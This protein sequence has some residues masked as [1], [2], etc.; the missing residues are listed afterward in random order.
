MIFVLIAFVGYAQN[1]SVEFRIGVS[2]PTGDFGDTDPKNL[3]AGLAKTGIFYSL[4]Y[5]YWFNEVAGLSVLGFQSTNA[6]DEDAFENNLKSNGTGGSN[7]NIESESWKLRLIGIGPS[8]ET[9][10]ADK[11]NLKTNL[12]IGLAMGSSA[13]LSYDEIMAGLTV[14]SQET[15]SADGNGLAFKVGVALEYELNDQWNINL[16]ADYLGTTIEYTTTTTSNSITPSTS[17]IERTYDQAMSAYL[18]GVGLS[19]NFGQ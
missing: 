15:S 16:N 9:S 1:G 8:I 13:E 5:T 10:L 18:F 6:F 11:I 7:F 3:E 19:Y 17:S 12:I 14:L 2:S 4:D